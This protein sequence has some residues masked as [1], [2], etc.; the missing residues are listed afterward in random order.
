MYWPPVKFLHMASPICNH[1]RYTAISLQSLHRKWQLAEC[2]LGYTRNVS[3]SKHS[4][5][6]LLQETETGS[7]PTR[8]ILC[9]VLKFKPSLAKH[10]A[11]RN[12]WDVYL[13]S[14]SS[15]LVILNGSSLFLLREVYLVTIVFS[16]QDWLLVA[17]V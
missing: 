15:V 2:S 14:L 3:V 12:S 17:S 4:L 16:E 1:E 10:H 8:W 13:T 11:K 9:Q 6:H 7:R 5:V